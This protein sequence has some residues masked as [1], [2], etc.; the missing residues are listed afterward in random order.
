M[1]ETMKNPSA[2]RMEKPTKAESKERRSRGAYRSLGGSPEDGEAKRVCAVLL[3]VLGGVR[4]PTEAAGVL[5][6]SVPRYYA[7]EARALGGFLK[8]CRRQKKGRR[9]SAES[10]L[11]HMKLELERASRECDR[12]AALLRTS[13]RAL[14]ISPRPKEP[15]AEPGKRKRK[16]PQVRALRAAR[17]L[18][19]TPGEIPLAV[20]SE[21]GD[22]ESPLKG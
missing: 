19:D 15:R 1:S 4:T 21:K 22:D 12:L 8:A 5:G 18:K 16:R 7:L 9:R 10:E 6:V 2:V 17:S 13:Q 14:G 20:K 11:G 3:E